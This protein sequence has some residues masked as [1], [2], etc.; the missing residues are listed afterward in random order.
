MNKFRTTEF[1]Q[2][3]IATLDVVDVG[4]RRHHIAALIEIDVTVSREKIKEYKKSIGKISFTAWLIKTIAV[5]LKEHEVA[6]AFLKGKRHLII[7][8]DITIS[9]LVEKELNGTKVPIPLVIEKANEKST[10]AIT[11]E[12]L[13]AKNRE[14]SEG[15]IVLHNKSNYWEKFYYQLPG[16]LRRYIWNYLSK[17][18]QVA[19]RKMGNVAIT[20][21]GM[22]GKVNGW[23][24]PTSV[25]PVCF[26]ISSITRK[27]W[28]INDNIEIRE[29]LNITILLDHDVID[30][31][32]MA[33]FIAN[34]TSTLEKG[35]G[36]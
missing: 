36:L 9:L 16:F 30:G 19:F 4:K 15:E 13:Q 10:E 32:Q 21:L 8:D 11:D 12:I 5:T 29:I 34:L 1:P 26:G 25:H 33:R 35:T 18:P 22:M 7:F 17:Q 14:F 2:S 20:S 6:A 28:V 24:I 3:R 27:P 31:A 23:F